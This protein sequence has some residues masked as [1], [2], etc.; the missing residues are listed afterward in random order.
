MS[1]TYTG[2]FVTWIEDWSQFFQP[3]N[4]YTFRPI[5]VEFEDDR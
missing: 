5:L 2:L 1:D 3:C 4:W